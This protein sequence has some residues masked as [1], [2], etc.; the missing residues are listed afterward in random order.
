MKLGN[1]KTR[2]EKDPASSV[3]SRGSVPWPQIPSRNSS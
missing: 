2:S 3:S 1:A